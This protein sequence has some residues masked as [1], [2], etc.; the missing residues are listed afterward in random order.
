M[1]APSA[2]VEVIAGA[3]AEPRVLD[4][5][6][7]IGPLPVNAHARDRLVRVLADE[8]PAGEV[9]EAIESDLSLL[10]GVMRL[11]NRRRFD[12]HTVDSVPG[13]I[14][15]VS[16]ATLQA[17]ADSTTVYDL[18]SFAGSPAG[19]PLSLH[20]HARAVQGAAHRVATAIG[21]PALD[22]VAVVAG[23]HDI[24]RLVI[25]EAWGPDAAASDAGS[26]TPRERLEAERDAFGID[27]ATAGGALLRAWGLP[28]RVAGAVERHHDVEAHEE[29]AIVGLAD[30]LVHFLD[31][32]PIDPDAILAQGGAL[33]IDR[34]ALARLAFDLPT[35]PVQRGTSAGSCPLSDREL[36]VVRKLAEGKV[37]KQIAHELGLS[38]ST[39][40]SHLHRVY[41]RIGAADRAHAVIMASEHGWL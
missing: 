26:G 20:R 9:V 40:R 2:Y 17:L 29:T 16:P 4:A 10:A 14:A 34:R 25:A 11:A 37:Y 5:V 13:A 7:R 38:P 1:E 36:A 31:G 21:F 22:R 6:R 27:H 18:F 32:D 28:D 35:G 3:A 24:G 23:L 12:R 41:G 8:R 30:M 19:V 39:I 15:A 33:G